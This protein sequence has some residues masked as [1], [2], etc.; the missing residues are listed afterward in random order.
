MRD[1]SIYKDINQFS[2][3][4]REYST[5]A[6]AI[7]QAVIN[8]LRT[9]FSSIP[10]TNWGIDL[11]EELFELYNER[12][13]QGLLFRIVSAISDQENRVI[14]DTSQSEVVLDFDNN[15]LSLILVFEIEGLSEGLFEIQEEIEF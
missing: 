10:F 2:P 7:Y 9:P 13:A 5:D 3:T 6:R 4:I 15:R 11:E 8:L 14:V 12:D 1:T